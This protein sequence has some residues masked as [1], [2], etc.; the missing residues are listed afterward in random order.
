MEFLEASAKDNRNVREAFY[1][2]AAEICRVKAQQQSVRHAP[3]ADH[4][5]IS[6]S[7]STR[8]PV[9]TEPESCGC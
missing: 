4:P 2:L 8:K 5:S 7:D 6:L 1:R 3:F 9:D